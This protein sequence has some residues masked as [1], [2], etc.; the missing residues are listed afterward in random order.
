VKQQNWRC[1]WPKVCF[2][3]YLQVARWDAE[4]YR[5]ELRRGRSI[6]SVG[7]P[8]CIAFKFLPPFGVKHI[9]NT[10]PSRHGRPTTV[11]CYM[12]TIAVM[13]MPPLHRLPSDPSLILS[14]TLT[15]SPF[16]ASHALLQPLVV[17]SSSFLL[18]LIVDLYFFATRKC[19]L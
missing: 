15:F 12:S 2:V 9:P 5:D 7:L 4:R 17:P 6:I 10:L 16:L 13:Y 8:Q 11:L 19:P 14:E 18:V 3:G 1:V